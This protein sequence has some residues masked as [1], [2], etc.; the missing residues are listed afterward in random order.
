MDRQA[1]AAEVGLSVH[2]LS[3]SAYVAARWPKSNRAAKASWAVYAI[4][5]AH[6]DRFNLIRD[7]MKVAEAQR[8][9]RDYAEKS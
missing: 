3:E 7:G 4:L 5:A 2:E 6:P 9:M 1:L 8:I